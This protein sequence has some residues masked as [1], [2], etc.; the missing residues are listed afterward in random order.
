MM[1]KW[2]YDGQE[3]IVNLLTVDLSVELPKSY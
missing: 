1:R 2:I 3:N